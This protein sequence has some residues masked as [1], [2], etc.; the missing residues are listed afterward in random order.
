MWELDPDRIRILLVSIHL[1]LGSVGFLSGSW[2]GVSGSMKTIDPTNKGKKE[3]SLVLKAWTFFS[4][5]RNLFLEF[6]MNDIL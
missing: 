2:V 5:S 6:V 3:I 4:E 1:G